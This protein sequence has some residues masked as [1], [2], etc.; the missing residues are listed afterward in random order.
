MIEWCPH[1]T[2]APE[3]NMDLSVYQVI[4]G[5]VIDTVTLEPLFSLDD[6]L[7]DIAYHWR[8]RSCCAVADDRFDLY[9]EIRSMIADYRMFKALDKKV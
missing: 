4:D 2:K 5:M 1:S 8:Q 7:G 3:G 6:M 9:R